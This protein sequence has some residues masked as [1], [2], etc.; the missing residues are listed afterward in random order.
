MKKSWT[1]ND[2][3][4]ASALWAEGQ[5]MGQIAQALG[6]S[7][8]SIARL[9]H[10]YRDQFESR[11][12]EVD[13]S[14]IADLVAQGYS[15]VEVAEKTGVNADT[16]RKLGGD[17][18]KGRKSTVSLVKDKPTPETVT[19]Q[20]EYREIPT[21]EGAL[22]KPFFCTEVGECSWILEDFWTEPRYDSPCCARPVFDRK[23]KG[24]KRTYCQYHYEASLEKQK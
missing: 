12:R 7:R 9:I 23:G 11:K 8:G 6:R 21:P 1:D 3:N 5:S 18:V 24:M 14:G 13:T 19:I 4:M 16:V 15:V 22:S 10:T 17:D 2:K 20:Y